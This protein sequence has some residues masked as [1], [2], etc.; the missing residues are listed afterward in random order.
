MRYATRRVQGL[1]EAGAVI[2]PAPILAALGKHG[3]SLLDFEHMIAKGKVLDYFT[4]KEDTTNRVYVVVG[5]TVDGHPARFSVEVQGKRG[6][7]ASFTW[8]A[9]R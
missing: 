3:H 8:L 4:D 5:V 9:T 7:I 1:W 6:K 2:V